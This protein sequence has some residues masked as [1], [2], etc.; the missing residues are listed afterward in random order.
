MEELSWGGDPGEKEGLA[1]CRNKPLCY[2]YQ[3]ASDTSAQPSC[4]NCTSKSTFKHI[5]NV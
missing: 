2:R 3:L 5:V 4:L 1:T